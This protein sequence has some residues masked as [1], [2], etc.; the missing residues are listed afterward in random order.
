MSLGGARRD[1]VRGL[2][3]TRTDLRIAVL[4]QPRTPDHDYFPHK[5]AWFLLNLE[6]IA[7]RPS[8]GKDA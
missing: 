3:G 7:H 4:T 2:T 5:R 8:T 1:R 6:P